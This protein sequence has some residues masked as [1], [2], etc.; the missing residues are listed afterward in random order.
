M[1]LDLVKARIDGDFDEHLERVRRFV[2]QPSISG[3][4]EGIPEMAEMVASE[5]RALGGN[6]RVVPTAGHPVVHG[7]IHA[8]APRTLLFYGMYDVQPVAGE[9]WIVPPFAGEITDFQEH[10]KCVVSR[11]I[12]N[13]KGPLATF[14]NTLHAFRDAG[15]TLP[16]NV[17]FVVEG[18]EELGSPNL[19]YFVEAH[20]E[21]LRADGCFFASFG[22]DPRGIPYVFLGVK[23][24]LFMELSVSGGEWGGPTSRMI[25]GSNA[26]WIASPSWRLIHVLRTL[27]DDQERILVGGFYDD[28]RQPTAKEEG[29]VERLAEVFD[30]SVALRQNDA[31]RFKHPGSGVEQLRHLLFDPTL[32]IDGM[33][34][35]YMGPGTKTLLPHEARV[36]LDVR[37]VPEM[38]P[39]RVFALLR[40]HLDGLGMEGVRLTVTDG[41]PWSRTD[42][43]AP[44]AQALMR[45][46]RAEGLEPYAWPRTAGSAPFYLFTRNLG[47]PTVAGGLG[48]GGRAHSPNEYATVEG[49]R[50]HERSVA[51][52]LLEFGAGRSD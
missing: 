4:G 52:F 11:G 33:E 17:K 51:A 24:I 37:M 36:R 50:A 49:I 39:D 1:S 43:D 48:H 13:Q 29:L 41:Y 30:D 19:P 18:E 25:H 14:L 2:R 15:V 47:V 3:T 44:V 16:V 46:I 8:G 34:A 9:E 7:E 10:G 31:R 21:A 38:E 40:R 28:V 6:A 5:I 32:N 45:A 12:S 23:G 27:V 42:P 26:A 35:G 22:Q 20:R